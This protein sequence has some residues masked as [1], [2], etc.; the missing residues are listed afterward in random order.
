MRLAG[1][2]SSSHTKPANTVVEIGNLVS[3]ERRSAFPAASDGWNN[4]LLGP[5]SNR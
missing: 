4:G 3:A 2:L 5:K 1:I